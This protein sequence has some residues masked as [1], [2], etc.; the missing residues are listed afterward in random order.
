M[1]ERPWYGAYDP[2]VPREIEP[3]PRPIPALVRAGL[4][5]D[6]DR[7]ALVFEEARWSRGEL[8]REIERC[9]AA[10][11][12]LGVG[13]GTRV[14]IH[15]PNLPQTVIGYQ[16]ALSLGAELV[17]TNPLYTGPE[18][19]HQWH[20]AE[21][22]FAITADYLF[23]QVL[24]PIRAELGVEQFVVATIAEYLPWPKRWLAPF[25]LARRTPPLAARVPAGPGLHRFRDLVR[26]GGERPSSDVRAESIAVL[27][28]TGGTTGPAKGALLSHANLT[29]NLRQME[30]W[31]AGERGE[32]EV[33]LGALPL[34]H[35]FG[36]TVAMN[37]SLAYGMKL[38]LAP[39]PRDVKALVRHIE[40]ERVSI[41]PAVP[42]MFN[43]INHLPGIERRDLSSLRVCVSGSAPI[44]PDV[45]ESFE[46]LT[47]A[48]ILEGFGMSETSPVTH[49]NPLRGE[50]RVG[51]IGLPLP[52]TDARIVD[53][54]Q[55]ERELP[56]GEPGELCI[57]GPQ[58]TSGYWNRP[59]ETAH[60]LRDGWLYTGD[61]ATMDADGYFHIVGR[62][63]DMINA[64]GYKIFPDEVDAVLVSHPD[65]LEAAT[66][67]IPDPRRGETTKSFVVA[68]PGVTIDAEALRRF[69]RERLA[70]YKVPREIEQLAELPKS[71]V[72]KVLRRELRERELRRR[73]EAEADRSRGA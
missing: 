8:L 21:V 34:F 46:R 48:R 63:K 65:V 38:V 24:A 69:C 61:L 72:M 42:A 51:S 10:L 13:A 54:E 62:K 45:L 15:L 44:A 39:D 53:S 19:L 1:P 26:R 29:A 25:V 71:A 28:Y 41:F 35:V 40:R 5:R 68:R 60:A 52:S 6:P 7:T 16:A 22:R 55:G 67:G 9:A 73:G 59:D 36:M 23:D 2:G 56:P 14:A 18:I 4:T 3:D 58:V 20:D 12:A 64:G 30:A 50:R 37:W 70:A 32:D 66:I 27:Q 47:G 43:A 33:M 31:F 57:C 49:V 17:L 11:H